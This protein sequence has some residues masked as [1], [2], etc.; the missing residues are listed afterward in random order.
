M[1]YPP[2]S[3]PPPQPLGGVRWWHVAI[4]AGGL[5]AGVATGVGLLFAT[6][7]LTTDAGVARADM[8]ERWDE[9]DRDTRIEICATRELSEDMMVTTFVEA[10]EERAAQRGEDVEVPREVVEEFLTEKCG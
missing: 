1:S 6:G 7:V 5:A 8:E 2:Q 9:L 10:F 4:L 3:P